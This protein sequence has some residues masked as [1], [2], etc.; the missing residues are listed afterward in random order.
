MVRIVI[1]WGNQSKSIFDVKYAVARAVETILTCHE[2]KT[3][4]Y[5]DQKKGA[6][7]GR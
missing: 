4:N 1:E 2:I 7:D 6:T 3:H 5:P